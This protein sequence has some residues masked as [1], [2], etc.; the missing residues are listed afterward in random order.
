MAAGLRDQNFFE[1]AERLRRVGFR[2]KDKETT[3]T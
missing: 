2:G 3:I 1:E